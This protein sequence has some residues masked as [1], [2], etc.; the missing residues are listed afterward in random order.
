MYARFSLTPG[1]P[2]FLRAVRQP[3]SPLIECL[4]CEWGLKIEVLGYRLYHTATFCYFEFENSRFQWLSEWAEYDH[5]S[6]MKLYRR[7]ADFF[8]PAAAPIVTRFADWKIL[9]AHTGL[10]ILYTSHTYTV[11]TLAVIELCVVYKYDD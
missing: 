5:S 11:R 4:T 8:L 7:L 6:S 2:A 1:P 3:Q 10:H 9:A